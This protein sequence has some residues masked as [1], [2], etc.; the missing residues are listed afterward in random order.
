MNRTAS[1]PATNVYTRSK[2]R[3]ELCWYDEPGERLINDLDLALLLPNGAELPQ[4]ADRTN[5]V[6]VIEAGELTA[7]RYV[8]RVRG[9]NVPASPQPFA[10]TVSVTPRAVA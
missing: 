5:T 10:L 4:T 8:L 9:F 2:Y 7:G 3:K 1:P 6:E